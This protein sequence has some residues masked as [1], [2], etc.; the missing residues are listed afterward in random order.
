MVS[1]AGGCPKFAGDSYRISRVSRLG[2]MVAKDWIIELTAHNFDDRSNGQY[3]CP[4]RAP[5]VLL[6]RMPA[7]VRVRARERK[8]A[9]F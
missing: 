6:V 1:L 2:V 9:W 8:W 7:W 5:R 4:D 3:N